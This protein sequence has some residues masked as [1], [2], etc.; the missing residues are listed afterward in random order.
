M[1]VVLRAHG[2]YMFLLTGGWSRFQDATGDGV[3]KDKLAA[4]WKWSAAAGKRAGMKLRTEQGLI[5]RVENFR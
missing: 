3:D 4:V 2:S 1:N 5:C